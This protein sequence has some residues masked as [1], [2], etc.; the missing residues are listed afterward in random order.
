LLVA[1][2][3]WRSPSGP[4]RAAG[5][6]ALIVAAIC[7][8]SRSIGGFSWRL[9][10]CRSLPGSCLGAVPALQSSKPDLTASMRRAHAAMTAGVNRV[11]LRNWFRRRPAR[12]GPGAGRRCRPA[13]AQPDAAQCDRDPRSSIR[14]T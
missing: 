6:G 11:R 4:A 5:D 14:I 7:R 3:A 1:R 12:I 9:R 2:W 13:R 10:C 8:R